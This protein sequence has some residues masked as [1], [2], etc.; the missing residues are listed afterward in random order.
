M[1]A[2]GGLLAARSGV[3]QSSSVLG[4]RAVALATLFWALDN[5]WTRPLA[6]FDTGRVVFGKAS[7]GA[8]LS[9]AMAAMLG[10]TWPGA[11]AALGLFGCDALGFG[12]S[13]RLY[14]R[15]QRELGAARTGSVFALAPFVGAALAFALGDRESA[16]LVVA[17]GGLFG[18]AVWLHATE[19]HEHRHHHEPL[20]HE[21][22]NRHD[23]GHHTHTHEPPFLGEHSH[24]HRHEALER[25]HVHASGLHHRHHE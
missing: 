5:T 25:A 24:F 12:L 1:L 6:D 22:A 19:A 11:R 4:L 10:E 14:L 23:D 16:L 15:A 17:A 21:H 13:L 9:A 2:G 18:F 8:G 7:I 20:D 3:A